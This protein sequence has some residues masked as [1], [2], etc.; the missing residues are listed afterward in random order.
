MG[1]HTRVLLAI[2]LIGCLWLLEL[3]LLLLG[4]YFGRRL[5]IKDDIV[6]G[7]RL[8]KLL[9]LLVFLL[10]WLFLLLLLWGILIVI[11]VLAE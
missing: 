10:Q 1:F 5:L 8:D 4:L 7:D 2:I 9:L 3:C 11:I 6:T